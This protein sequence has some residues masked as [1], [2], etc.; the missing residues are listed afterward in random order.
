[1][2]VLLSAYACEP[3][4]GSEPGVGW[5]WAN[6]LSKH[7]DVTVVTRSNNE[8]VI[9]R[10]YAAHGDD[11]PRPKFSYY[12]PPSWVLW[13]KKK[14]LL[15]VQV[16]YVVWQL[17]VAWKHRGAGRNYDLVHH[18]TFNSMM[19]P[20]FWWFSSVPVVLGPL[21]GTSCVRA[22]YRPLFGR[23]LWKERLRETLI[24]NWIFL[25]WIRFS[26]NRAATI[27][28]ANSDTRS[29]VDLRYAGK[30]QTMLET[31]VGAPTETPPRATS[32][33]SSFRFIWVGTIEPWKALTLA[34]NGFERALNALPKNCEV[35]LD[36]VGKGSEKRQA[37]EWV[38][39]KGLAGQVTFY[40]QVSTAEVD[41]MMKGAGAL[42]FSSVKDTSG[43]VVLEAML[44]S[45]PV[46][47][48]NHQGVGDMTTDETAIRIAP[49]SIE[50]TVKG[51]ADAIVKLAT[52]PELANKMGDAGCLRVMAEYSWSRRA[53]RM[54]N[55]YRAI[56]NQSNN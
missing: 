2:K 53:S 18:V 33:Q 23:R 13:L 34:L 26:F 36:V 12:D 49:G 3:D 8:D 10:W 22:E 39:E 21:G 19:M 43:N 27:L 6:S 16:F 24:R 25:P 9:E 54:H 30:T 1:M 17:G 32:K 29:Q 28:C 41:A 7:A 31:G 11:E 14:R 38:R 55:N 45:L 4:R 46:I 56:T 51:M 44:N 52:Q 15:P 37:E 5:S 48:I 40:G 50:A 20:G 35:H 42:I 47:C